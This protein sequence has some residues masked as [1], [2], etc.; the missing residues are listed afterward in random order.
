MNILKPLIVFFALMITLNARAQESPVNPDQ[1]TTFFESLKITAGWGT[2]NYYG[3]LMKSSGMF[4]QTTVTSA[5]LG[6][7]YPISSRFNCG[8]N[9]GLQKLQGADSKSGGAHPDRNLDFKSTVFHITANGEY[10][11]LPESK[12]TPVISAGIGIMFFDPTTEDATGKEVKLREL[13]T[14]GQGL[15]GFKELYGKSTWVVP[16]GIGVRYNIHKHFKLG[17]E[18]K[19]H[20]TG[21]DYLDDVSMNGYPDKALLDARN[22][23][24]SQFTYRGAGSYPKNQALP[25]GN[26]KDK[27]GFYTFQLRFII[28][29]FL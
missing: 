11:P 19:Y 1:G 10:L 28:T 4:K 26:P 8:I 7:L 16:L 24:T 17:M 12:I 15:P 20:F 22:P 23:Q 6:V 25:R 9:F 27:D 21:T 5:S 18:Y 2:S 14:E 13:A 3:D 29:P